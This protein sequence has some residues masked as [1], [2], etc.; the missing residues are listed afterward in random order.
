MNIAT[1]LN[2]KYLEYTA[3]VLTSLC[4]NNPQEKINAYLL[5]HELTEEDFRTIS[6][7]LA[8][9]EIEVIS[10]KVD[11]QRFSERLPGNTKW[12]VDRE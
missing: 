5:Y 6:D 4:E 11:E 8:A 3:V 10:M 1:A 2:R 9:Y 12:S 7:A